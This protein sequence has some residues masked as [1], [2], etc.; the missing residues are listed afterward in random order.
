MASTAIAAARSTRRINLSILDGNTG[1]TSFCDGAF[2][3]DVIGV[4]TCRLVLSNKKRAVNTVAYLNSYSECSAP[5]LGVPF[6]A[7][8]TM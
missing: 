4:D 5:I 7:R 1:D 6:R 8:R 3:E 2:N